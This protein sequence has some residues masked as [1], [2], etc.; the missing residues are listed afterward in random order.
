MNYTTLGKSNLLVS[1]I[2]LG[3]MHFG[4][5]TSQE[6]AFA[7]MDRALEMGINFFDTANVYG[8]SGGRGRTEEIIGHWFRQGG[9]RRDRVVLAT[10]VYGNMVDPTL[11]NE[12]R[13]LSAYKVRKHLAD[14]LRR[15]AAM[16][17]HFDLGLL[18]AFVKVHGVYPRGA[19]VRLSSGE[20]GRVVE[21]SRDLHRPLV[22]VVESA[23]GAISALESLREGRAG[24]GDRLVDPPGLPETDAEL[25]VRVE[26]VRVST[27][28]LLEHGDGL[29]GGPS[30]PSRLLAERG[31]GPRER[32]DHRRVQ[33]ADVDAQHGRPRRD[34]RA[35]VQVGGKVRTTQ[36]QHRDHD[37][38]QH[39]PA[40]PGACLLGR[41]SCGHE[42]RA[43]IDPSCG[44][45]TGGGA[46]GG[47]A[48]CHGPGEVV[49][50]TRAVAVGPS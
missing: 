42:R 21:Q 19:R 11:P 3:T 31:N 36:H 7:I 46:G 33:A 18:K 10:K 17:E 29:V 14:S 37:T 41:L 23:E 32:R 1:R 44:R 39:T 6:D 2:C 47:F 28:G 20:V 13:G 43:S 22:Q 26:R 48:V 12:A 34:G 15:L 8:G 9:G 24:R 35:C 16:G 45:G 25:E 30:R 38:G 4:S 5:A 49:G 27:G 50:P 40:T